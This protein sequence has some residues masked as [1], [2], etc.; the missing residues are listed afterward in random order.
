[1][2][3]NRC[4]NPEQHRRRNRRTQRETVHGAGGQAGHDVRV[5]DREDQVSGKLRVESGK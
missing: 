2:N 4:C 5:A 1:M 3:L